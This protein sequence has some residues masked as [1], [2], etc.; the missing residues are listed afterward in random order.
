[1]LTQEQII[2]LLMI[3]KRSGN[4]FSSLPMQ[5]SDKFVELYNVGE[6]AGQLAKIFCDELYDISIHYTK[7]RSFFSSSF[8]HQATGLRTMLK[9]IFNN[10]QCDNIKRLFL[11]IQLAQDL[12]R[13]LTRNGSTRFKSSLLIFMNNHELLINDISTHPLL[14]IMNEMPYCFYNFYNYFLGGCHAFYNSEKY[15]AQINIHYDNRINLNQ[16]FEHNNLT[17]TLEQLV[18][19]FLVVHNNKVGMKQEKIGK[20]SVK[21]R[22]CDELD[23]P[24]LASDMHQL[25]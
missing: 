15:F 16:Y 4:L 14:T 12:Y 9:I 25:L 20:M 17:Y 6:E 2:N 8:E 7:G 10:K 21:P 13:Y 24:E 19:S 23:I 11:L 3:R 18:G 22:P 5:I 1:M